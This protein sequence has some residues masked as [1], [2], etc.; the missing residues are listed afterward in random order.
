MFHHHVVV[1]SKNIQETKLTISVMSV[2]LTRNSLDHRVTTNSDLNARISGKYA[3]NYKVKKQTKL[4]WLFSYFEQ[5]SLKHKFQTI[6]FQIEVSSL[7]LEVLAQYQPHTGID[8]Q[9]FR[10]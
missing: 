5:I 8:E 7:F 2:L 6:C 3:A 9:K 4:E 10:T 1:S